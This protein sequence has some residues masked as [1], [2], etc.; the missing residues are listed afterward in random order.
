MGT[1]V[2]GIAGYVSI[3][4]LLRMLTSHTLW[5]FILYRLALAAALVAAVGGWEAVPSGQ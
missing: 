5:P 2:A 1:L 4:W 3:R